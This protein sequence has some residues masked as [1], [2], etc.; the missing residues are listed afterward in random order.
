MCFVCRALSLVPGDA[1]IE[2]ELEIARRKDQ[3]Q[4]VQRR[5]VRIGVCAVLCDL[6]PCCLSCNV[7]L[8]LNGMVCFATAQMMKGFMQRALAKGFGDEEPAVASPQPTD[9]AA[10]TADSAAASGAVSEQTDK[11][12]AASA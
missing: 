6:V 4:E 3:Q 11:S 2:R 9:A 12:D 8:S 5:K 10:V 1:M 7:L